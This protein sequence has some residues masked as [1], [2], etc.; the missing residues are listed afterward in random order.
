MTPYTKQIPPTDELDSLIERTL[1]RDAETTRSR[2]AA[3]PDLRLTSKLALT[4]ASRG[5]LGGLASKLALYTGAT[6]VVGGAMY[7]IPKLNEQPAS[8]TPPVPVIHQQAPTISE[9]ANSSV[10]LNPAEV[11]PSSKIQ[12]HS[13]THKTVSSAPSQPMKLDEGDD[14]NIKKIVDR[15]YLPPLK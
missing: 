2:F 1:A 10:A 7:F 8:R 11:I 14:K 15:N 13:T 3:V 12:D 5:L 9:P 6:L 4:T